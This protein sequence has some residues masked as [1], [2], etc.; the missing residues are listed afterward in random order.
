MAVLVA[1]DGFCSLLIASLLGRDTDWPFHSYRV[2]FPQPL[3]THT[4][5]R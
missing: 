1:S 5:R 4:H 3:A 2:P